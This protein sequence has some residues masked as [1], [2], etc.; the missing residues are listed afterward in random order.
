MKGKFL[1]GL[2]SALFV[3][4]GIAGAGLINGD[5]TQPDVVAWTQYR[6]NVTTAIAALDRQGDFI[7][8]RNIEQD[9][10]ESSHSW[11]NVYGGKFFS[12]GGIV[13]AMTN[14][15]LV[16]SSNSVG[17]VQF[18]ISTTTL[19]N[20]GGGTTYATIDLIISTTPRNIVIQSSFSVN[21]ATSIL[22]GGATVYGV[23]ARGLTRSELIQFS[24]AITEGNIAWAQ[25]S[26]ITIQ[27][28]S[29]SLVGEQNVT[30]KI[31]YGNKIG[32][33]NDLVLTS[34][35]YKVTASNG[36]GNLALASQTIDLT[37]DTITFSVLP[38]GGR[39][40]HLWYKAKRST[41]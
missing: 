13:N 39:E 1:L 38:N 33:V 6:N 29:T 36:N 20:A 14:Y 30:I 10:G 19:N 26:S 9:L 24:T 3:G 11:R 37:E 15:G 22:A 25:I 35:I 28:S 16:E 21:M 34:D 27:T 12:T 7:P 31:G 32:L 40:F 17:A 2:I 41:P 18:L 4:T 23:D 8:G 5:P